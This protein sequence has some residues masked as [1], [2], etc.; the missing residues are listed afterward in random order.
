MR[1]RD[2]VAI[3]TGGGQGLGAAFAR[4]FAE[5]GA[6]LAVVDL[7]AETAQETAERIV[8][9]HGIPQKPGTEP[10]TAL[11]YAAREPA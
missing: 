11:S 3:V 4:K 8:L 7:N 1:L 6:R 5:E 2:K 10:R 9:T